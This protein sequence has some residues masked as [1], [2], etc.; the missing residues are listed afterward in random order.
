MNYPKMSN[1]LVQAFVAHKSDVDHDRPASVVAA[2]RKALNEL[3]QAHNLAMAN[4][5]Y[6]AVLATD[7]PMKALV[8]TG[9]HAKFAVRTNKES[10]ALEL[11]SEATPFMLKDFLAYAKKSDKDAGVKSDVLAKGYAMR[12]SLN[13]RLAKDLGGDTAKF[14]EAYGVTPANY[15]GEPKKDTTSNTQ[16]A[17]LLKVVV[18]SFGIEGLPVNNFDV[19][20]MKEAATRMGRELGQLVTCSENQFWLIVLSVLRK[21]AGVEGYKVDYRGGA[22]AKADK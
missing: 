18:D 15:V 8:A 14:R 2:S 21:V 7:T 1:E 20:Y 11:A 10:K 5:A 22:K 12:F 16:L 17:K 3:L 6:D 4:A 9:Y 19:N 13:A